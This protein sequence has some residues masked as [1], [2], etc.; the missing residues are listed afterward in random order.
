IIELSNLLMQYLSKGKNM[1]YRENLQQLI[2]QQQKLFKELQ[3]NKTEDV[4]ARFRENDKKILAEFSV[5]LNDTV[6]YYNTCN[7]DELLLLS[8]LIID[9]S[10]HFRSNELVNCFE[11]RVDRLEDGSLKKSLKL[12]VDFIKSSL[13]DEFFI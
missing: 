3:Q 10:K 11:N 6:D 12:E 2:M 8:I 4:I 1:M 13:K 9:L 5:N 7:A